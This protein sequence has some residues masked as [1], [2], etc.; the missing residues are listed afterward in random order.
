MN[1]MLDVIFSGSERRKPTNNDLQMF[2]HMSVD[3]LLESIRDLS[4]NGSAEVVRNQPNEEFH[5]IN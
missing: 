3:A 2:G 1:K 4:V 5:T